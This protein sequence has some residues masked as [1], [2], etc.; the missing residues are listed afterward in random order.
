MTRF[1]SAQQLA[2][3]A[4]LCPGKKQR[5]GR[6]LSGRTT[7]GHV[8]LRAVLAEVAW[9][10]PRTSGNSVVALSP[11]WARRRGTQKAI[12][13]RAHNLLLSSSYLLR[14]TQ[15]SRA[16]GPA[17]CDHRESVRVHRPE[18]HR[19]EQLGLA[20]TLPPAAAT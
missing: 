9:A 19:R 4:G 5:G 20:V 2:S 1:P 13:A 8:G 18:V 6:R 12:S 17:H 15:P 14:A 11:R 3:W 7:T 16:L 10:I